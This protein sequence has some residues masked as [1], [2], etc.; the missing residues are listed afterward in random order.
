MTLEAISTGPIVEKLRNLRDYMPN[1]E[2]VIYKFGAYLAERMDNQPEI[3]PTG[4]NIA[5]S[6][7]LYD[8]EKGVN[9]F[10]GQPIRNSLVGYPS[11]IYG[12]LEM[13]VPRMAEAV[14]PPEFAQGVKE[15][16][17]S[18]SEDIKKNQ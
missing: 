15:M 4:F 1:Q 7:A 2:D 13:T 18:V 8:L 11:Q 16:A 10:T 6:L 5:A 9:G 12:L 14:C 3:V 17:D